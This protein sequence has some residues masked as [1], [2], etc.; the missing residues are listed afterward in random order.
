MEMQNDA[1]NIQENIAGTYRVTDA[2]GK[3][4]FENKF[5]P[6]KMAPKTQIRYAMPWDN[7]TLAPGNYAVTL[8]ANM[9]G[10]AITGTKPLTIGNNQV[11]DYI[12]RHPPVVPQ[13]QKRG[14][15]TWVWIVVAGAVA[16]GI[17]YWLGVRKAKRK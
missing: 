12:Q 6:F 15:P 10:Q 1:P 9:G 7:P 13:A 11:G 5:N 2:S 3:V 14:I 17:M 16:G 4:L 8:T